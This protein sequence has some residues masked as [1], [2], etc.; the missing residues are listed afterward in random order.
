MSKFVSV[1]KLLYFKQKLES[2]FTLKTNA[3][4]TAID[5]EILARQTADNALDAELTGIRVG[6]TGHRY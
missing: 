1:D 6:Y 2:L 4:Q 3:I 5:N